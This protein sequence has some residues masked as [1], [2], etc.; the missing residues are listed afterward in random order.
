MVAQRDVDAQ[1]GAE[2]TQI[3]LD[4]F[5]G[6]DAQLVVD[7][8][9][10]D[11]DHV[12]LLGIAELHEPLGVALTDR[13]AEVGVRHQHHLQAVS[14][15]RRLGDGDP[16]VFH[17]GV[18]DV[19]ITLDHQPNREKGQQQIGATPPPESVCRDPC[20]EPARPTTVDPAAEIEE[21]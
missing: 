19:V 11:D 20:G 14:P 17:S 10:S 15:G 9:A 6:G 1:G 21:E 7:H 13:L 4:V 8:V 18:F 12:R 5:A 16:D 2:P 3:L